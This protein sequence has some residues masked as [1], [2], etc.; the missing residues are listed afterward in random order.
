MEGRSKRNNNMDINERVLVIENSLR[1][2]MANRN[3][4]KTIYSCFYIL[5]SRFQHL[6]EFG[7]P[8][9]LNEKLT[10]SPTDILI[11]C[12][13]VFDR[14]GGGCAVFSTHPIICN[15]EGRRLM[16]RLYEAMR[17]LP[18]STTTFSRQKT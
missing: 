14:P 6:S 15:S 13:G 1:S 8:E 7:C 3:L 18:F 16:W 2:P 11:S 5:V 12:G 9:K 10:Y 4:E 17:I